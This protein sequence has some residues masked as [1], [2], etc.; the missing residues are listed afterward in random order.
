MTR[1]ETVLIELF[2]ARPCL[3]PNKSSSIF[4]QKLQIIQEF[5]TSQKDCKFS[6]LHSV[7]DRFESL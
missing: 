1:I 7:L 4:I 2:M 3:T 5:H 6:T